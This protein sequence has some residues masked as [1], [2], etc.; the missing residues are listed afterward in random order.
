M[1]PLQQAFVE[2]FK[3]WDSAAMAN[4]LAA[5]L[6]AFAGKPL[7][8]ETRQEIG[9]Q[10]RELL[11]NM[12]LHPSNGGGLMVPEIPAHFIAGTG[13]GRT[14]QPETGRY[15]SL[16]LH[17]TLSGQEAQSL[18]TRWQ[19]MDFAAGDIVVAREE[20][21]T[22]TPLKGE[23]GYVSYDPEQPSIHRPQGNL[24]AAVSHTYAYALSVE[25][26]ADSPYLQRYRAGEC[27][28]VWDELTALG[29]AARKPDIL[30]HA[31]AVARE[32]MQRCRINVEQI[33]AR[34]KRRV[35]FA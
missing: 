2:A 24:Q 9:W 22:P 4:A 3:A 23:P 12:L 34:L 19:E 6:E 25:A 10:C 30:P 29:D 11:Y 33:Y 31:V 32:T 8:E 28:Q 5:M 27:K 17:V 7:S 20:V 1:N 21:K 13:I 15:S 16:T 26:G 35:P 18:K 14:K